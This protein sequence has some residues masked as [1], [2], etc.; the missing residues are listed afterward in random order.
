MLPSYVRALERDDLSQWLVHLVRG[1][2]LGGPFSGLKSILREFAIRPSTH[3]AVTPYAPQ[4]AVCFY[5][6]PWTVLGKLVSSNPSG[7]SAYGMVVAKT[8][9]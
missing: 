5:D 9:L 8:A 2:A 4:G 3:F 7:R 6:V 1:S